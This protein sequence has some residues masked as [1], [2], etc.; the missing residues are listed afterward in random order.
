[1][2]GRN[3][4]MPTGSGLCMSPSRGVDGEKFCLRIGAHH[5]P[6]AAAE[7]CHRPDLKPAGSPTQ[8]VTENR[9]GH[10]QHF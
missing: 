4:T 10:H 5:P 9:Y 3:T 7:P 8:P 6:S 1:M 2:T